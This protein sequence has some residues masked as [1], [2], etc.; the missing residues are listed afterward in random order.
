MEVPRPHPHRKSCG[1]SLV[2]TFAHTTVAH[3]VKRVLF[4]AP[5]PIVW[6]DDASAAVGCLFG[7][8]GGGAA[9]AHHR[10]RHGRRR[11][12]RRRNRRGRPRGRRGVSRGR[13]RRLGPRR[14]AVSRG[15]RRSDG[16][17]RIELSR[18]VRRRP[19]E[20]RRLRDRRRRH[21]RRAPRQVVPRGRRSVPVRRGRAAAVR[22]DGPAAHRVRLG[23]R[24]GARQL[25]GAGALLREAAGED[26]RADARVAAGHVAQADPDRGAR[27][28]EERRARFRLRPRGRRQGE[29]RHQDPRARRG[30]GRRHSLSA[31]RRFPRPRAEVLRPVG[32]EARRHR[33]WLY[34]QAHALPGARHRDH[35]PDS[36]HQRRHRARRAGRARRHLLDGSNRRHAQG[37]RHR[38]ADGRHPRARRRHAAEMVRWRMVRVPRAPRRAREVR[39]HDSPHPRFLR[40]DPREEAR[41]SARHRIPDQDRSRRGSVEVRRPARPRPAAEHQAGERSQ[42]HRLRR[43]RGRWREGHRRHAAQHR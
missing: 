12:T 10:A 40:R 4:A 15:G 17:R 16:A 27:L 6:R 43:R 33:F 35:H 24:L 18:R 7:L 31:Q 36:R 3:C 1:G 9:R 39:R 19:I 28:E 13:A 37:W 32:V 21:A 2:P 38:R 14:R 5:S 41:D 23:H 26:P 22:E 42:R 30:L 20:R 29:D 8:L 25:A 34:A 11:L